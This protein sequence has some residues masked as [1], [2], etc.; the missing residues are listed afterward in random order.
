MV[1]AF[2][3]GSRLEWC[4]H[5]TFRNLIDLLRVLRSVFIKNSNGVLMISEIFLEVDLFEVDSALR[6]LGALAKLSH[7]VHLQS[8]MEA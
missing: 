5:F 3:G 4:D 2:P 8:W 7:H 1:R 6:S